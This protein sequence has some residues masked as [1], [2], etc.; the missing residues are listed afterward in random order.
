MSRPAQHCG[1]IESNPGN[2]S[3]QS[4]VE[5]AGLAACMRGLVDAIAAAAVSAS[6]GAGQRYVLSLLVQSDHLSVAGR[7][8]GRDAG[9]VIAL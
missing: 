1:N 5:W 2:S 9:W 8:A 6:N 3:I 4:A 7:E